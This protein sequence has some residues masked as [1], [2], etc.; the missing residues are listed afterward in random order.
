MGFEGIAVEAL[1]VAEE[2]RVLYLATEQGLQAS[3]DSGES[4]NYIGS[5]L[6]AQGA[7][8][9]VSLAADPAGCD[10]LYAGTGPGPEGGLYASRDGGR[11]WQRL[12]AGR[13]QDGVRAIFAPGKPGA[14]LRER[15]DR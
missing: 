15:H 7:P 1:A 9:V 12:F 6:D 8:P 11:H 5:D 3:F 2:G 4:W 14:V 13:R 10:C